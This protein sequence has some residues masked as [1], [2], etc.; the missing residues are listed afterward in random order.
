MALGADLTFVHLSDIHF[1][2]GR[3]ETPHDPD[4]ELRT[5][6]VN[7][8]RRMASKLDPVTGLII[9]GDIAWQG[10]PR[11]YTFADSWIRSVAEHLRCPI[12]NVMVT[13]GNHDV[14]RPE[15]KKNDSAIA[16]AHEQLRR[17]GNSNIS[18]ERLVAFLA[19]KNGKSLL[20]PLRAY[21]KFAKRFSCELS[22]KKP[23]WERPF[24]MGNGVTLKVRGL[25]STWISGPKDSE[26]VARLLYG[27][28]QY[29]FK[30][31]DSV[32]YLVAGHHPPQNMIDGDDAAKAFDFHC[33]LQLFGHKHDQ[34]IWQS[35]RCVRIVSG[36]LHPDRREKPW[37]PRYNIIAISG[38]IRGEDK[39]T[40][41]K[42]FPRRW[43][44]EFRQFMADFTPT[45]DPDRTIEFL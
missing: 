14:C 24:A 40:T 3:T 37:I 43:S 45:G 39:S 42:I 19:G 23:Y 4:V 12:E 8:L 15:L 32:A 29:S 41:I 18:S 34:W 33:R 21:N 10:H 28:A 31:D 11:E 2:K 26:K 6:L 38:S 1:R 36:A 30:K 17:G 44:E 22:P 35:D 13:P 9:T 7:D 25:N 27:P 5:E 20:A 16:K